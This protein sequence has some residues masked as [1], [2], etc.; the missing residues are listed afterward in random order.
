M[1]VNIA[2]L[3]DILCCFFDHFI[4]ESARLLYLSAAAHDILISPALYYLAIK[5]FP[6]TRVTKKILHAYSFDEILAQ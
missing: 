1:S 3:A 6:H 4:T 5:V 2:D